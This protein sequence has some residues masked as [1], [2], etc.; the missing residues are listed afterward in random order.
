MGC[1]VR[2]VVG[3]MV[4]KTSWIS[5][6]V[7]LFSDFGRWRREVSGVLLDDSFVGEDHPQKGGGGG[8]RWGLAAH[9]RS[10]GDIG[11]RHRGRGVCR[12]RGVETW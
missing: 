2:L 10:L 3:V 5:H 7:L 1:C 6:R 4:S 12:E 8:W 11:F 9:P